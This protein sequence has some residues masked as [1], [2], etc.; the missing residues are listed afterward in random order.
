LQN[1]TLGDDKI[2]IVKKIEGRLTVI[3][4][5]KDSDVKFA[6]FTPNRYVV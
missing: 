3:V 1:F 5:Q 6:Y 2:I 4:K